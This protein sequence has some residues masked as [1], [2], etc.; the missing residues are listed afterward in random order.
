MIKRDPSIE[1][2]ANFKSTLFRMYMTE[3]EK[4]DQHMDFE[5]W[6]V[7]ELIFMSYLHVKY[8]NSE[9]YGKNDV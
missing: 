2:I 5:S 3:M 4:S 8:A 1:E 7:K 9:L 6:L